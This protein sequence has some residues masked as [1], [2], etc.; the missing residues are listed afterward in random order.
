M[1]F[2]FNIRI[3][4]W[5]NWYMNIISIKKNKNAYQRGLSPNPKPFSIQGKNPTLN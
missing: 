1:F 3:F 5:E 2:F 4:F